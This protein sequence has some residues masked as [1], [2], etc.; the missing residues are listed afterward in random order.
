MNPN[1]LDHLLIDTDLILTELERD[2][3]LATDKEI[4][5]IIENIGHTN[6]E[7]QK[8]LFNLVKDNY[9]VLPSK[10]AELKVKISKDESYAS[11][12]LF[13]PI[14]NGKSID[15]ATLLQELNQNGVKF[16]IIEEN[17]KEVIKKHENLDI[18]KD[19]V[20]ARQK[21]P[22]AGKDGWL[23]W[24]IEFDSTG[25]SIKPV[26]KDEIIL[27]CHPEDKGTDGIT[28]KGKAIKPPPTKNLELNLCED[29]KYNPDTNVVTSLINGQ[30]YWDGKLLTIKKYYFIPAD[31]DVSLG[32]LTFSGDIEIKGYVRSG[33]YLEAD[34]N[35]SIGGGV[36]AA[37]IKSING[38][39][40][41]K[42]GIQGS[43]KGLISA[44]K[45]VEAKFIENANII[46]GEK[47]VVKSAI[48]HSNI[49]SGGDVV[50]EEGKG[51]IIGGTIKAKDSVRAKFIGSYVGTKTEIY[52]GI[53][54]DI[55]KKI[56]AISLEMADL[57]QKQDKIEKV[58][59]DFEHFIKNLNALPPEKRDKLIQLKKTLVAVKYRIFQLKEDEEKL[60]Q[61]AYSNVLGYVKVMDTAFPGSKI[62]IG[63]ESICLNTESRYCVFKEN[64]QSKRIEITPI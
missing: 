64:K 46:A 41:I 8:E 33:L 38:S 53:S 2:G 51:F 45:I 1:Q 57:I 6:I 13:P 37:I 58:I 5:E 42:Q 59:Y 34:G 27:I 18:I 30:A 24:K 9:K 49:L 10:D 20:I 12:D 55:L 60:M 48:L 39:V 43:G 61:G 17:L 29:F 16:G 44:A 25:K 36:E 19:M 63:N 56:E 3:S 50:V 23:E 11:I 22:V 31:L 26:N 21:D 54:L 47:V 40:I 15:R 35:I 62:S 52:I 14:G 4:R 7:V 28:V 32:N